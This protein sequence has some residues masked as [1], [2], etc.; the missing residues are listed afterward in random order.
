MEKIRF[1]ST[2]IEVT[3]IAFGAWAIGGWLWGGADAQDAIKAMHAAFDIGITTI[4]TAP[5]YGFGVSEELVAKALATA[6][7][8]RDKVV[9]ATK[10]GMEWDEDENT[11]NNSRPERIRE[12]I[13]QS[14]RRLQTDYIDIYQIHWPD[15][16]TPIEETAAVMGELLAEGK[17][18]A[19]GVC[20]YSTEQMDAWRRVAPLHSN[21]VRFNL[22]ERAT[23][24]DILPYCN[25]HGMGF[26]AYSPLARG[27]LTGKYDTTSVF[28]EGDSRGRDPRFTGDGGARNV[29]I[30]RKL[31]EMA[32]AAGKSVAQLAVRWV[33]DRDANIVALWGARRPDQI[34]AAAGLSGW[35][36][37]AGDMARIDEIVNEA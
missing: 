3:R 26:M 1:G 11:W 36:L 28:R 21:Q 18:R 5:V 19:I 8:S 24:A 17:V 14:L 16:N 32:E 35:T 33:L 37:S 12:E 15:E 22:I 2:D 31:T 7:V 30:V 20:N 23:E 6:G 13:E 34:A 29:R 4:D 25:E 10:A 27:L 9:L